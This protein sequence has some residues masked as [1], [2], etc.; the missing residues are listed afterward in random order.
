MNHNLHQIIAWLVLLLILFCF[1]YGIPAETSAE[2][3]DYSHRKRDCEITLL[4]NNGEPLTNTLIAI[5][6]MDN[7]FAFGGTIRSE[8]FDTL[9]DG[10]GDSFLNY[11]DVGTPEIE[12]NWEYVMKCSQKCD[13]DFSKADFLV[14]WMLEK[15]IPIRG[16]NLF[17]N[18]K[19]DWIPQWTRTLD[20]VA[21]KHVMLERIDA[22]MGHFKGNV[23]Q[24][25]LI[26]QI[27]HGKNCSFYASGI[28]QT[29]SGDPDNFNWII[30]EAS[31]KRPH[32][33][34]SPKR[35]RYHYLQ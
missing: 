29:K 11:F 33:R 12:M 13:P 32:G 35:L 3:Y 8:A 27:C 30:E 24:W 2:G 21:F 7:D 16:H 6:I 26:N 22:T 9:G 23:V 15:K 14:N 4:S 18:E 10:Y 5:S 19:E 28:L 31:K 20:T 1:F 25:D 17:C 34:F